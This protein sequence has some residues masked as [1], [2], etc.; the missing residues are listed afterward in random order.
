MMKA[1]LTYLGVAGCTV[2][3][4][5]L[6]FEE[7]ANLFYWNVVIACA[8][9]AILLGNLPLLSNEKW[10][11]FKNAASYLVLNSFALALF[12]WTTFYTLAITD[13]NNFDTL[14]IGLATI[15]IVFIALLGVIEVGGGFMQ[16][17]E[18]VMDQRVA[19]KKRTIMSV[20]LFWTEIQDE[21]NNQTDWEEDT[22][23]NIRLVLDKIASIPAGKIERNSDVISEINGKLESL[24]EKILTLPSS[25][26][27]EK[28]QQEITK[29]I[30]RIANYVV[31]IKST[32]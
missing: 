32:L 15:G 8:A 27:P 25:D 4:Y 11:T 22:L 20:E 21:L 18:A 10:L 26:I 31:T 12:A 5:Y 29:Q 17:Q 1:I 14:Y 16:K 3:L 23:R 7:H 28:A 9:E 13:G 19:V 30:Q 2:L 24:K 6:I